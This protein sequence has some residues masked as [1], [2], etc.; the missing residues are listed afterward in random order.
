MKNYIPKYN[1][2]NESN[3]FDDLSFEEVGRLVDIGVITDFD[4]IKIYNYVYE[5]RIDEPLWLAETKLTHL[6]S[7]LVEVDSLDISYSNIKEIP[8]NLIITGSVDANNSQLEIF[9][10]TYINGSLNLDNCKIT[11]L[12]EGLE[13]EG[14]LSI[15][16][17][18]LSEFPEYMRI[19]DSIFIGY[20]N[21]MQFSDDNLRNKYDIGYEIIRQ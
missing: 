4:I 6:P 20:S 15:E 17:L 5:D 3:E 18:Q 14:T 7:W 9:N 10:H 19:C 8:Q 2:I 21:L 11:K 12:P 13:V 16:Y 1:Q